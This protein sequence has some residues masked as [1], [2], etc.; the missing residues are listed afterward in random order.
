M[1]AG[2]GVPEAAG[3][4]EA[5]VGRFEGKLLAY[6]IGIV[7]SA[8]AARDVVQDVFVRLCAQDRVSVEGHLAEWLYRVCRN[9]ALDVKRKERRMR[10]VSEMPDVESE[11]SGAAEL[12]EG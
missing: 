10:I 2:H 11:R 6:A 1:D 8:E 3:W 9:R 7:G 12:A 5:A 4:V